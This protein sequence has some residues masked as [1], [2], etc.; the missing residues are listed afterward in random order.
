[1]GNNL[2]RKEIARRR[3]QSIDDRQILLSGQQAETL[4]GLPYRS[5]CDLHMRG[6]LPAVRFDG[7]RRLWFRRSDIDRLIANSLTSTTTHA[8]AELTAHE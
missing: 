8:S 6:L 7:G 2:S 5:I 1:V 3:A 4:T